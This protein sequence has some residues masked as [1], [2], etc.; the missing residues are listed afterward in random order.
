MALQTLLARNE[1]KLLHVRHTELS[2][3]A[4]EYESRQAELE[5]ALDEAQTEDDLNA[6]R[7]L[8]SEFQSERDA[9]QRNLDDVSAQIAAKET[10]LRELEA[11][12]PPVNAPA[13][14]RK[15]ARPMSESPTKYR[16]LAHMSPERRERFLASTEVT[17]FVERF[18]EKF[19]G[20]SGGAARGVSG[21]ELLIP[22][23]VLEVLRE[24][25]ENYSRLARYV[26][27]VSLNG[28]ARLPIMGAIPEAVWTEVC[29]KLNE[30]FLTVG[31]V[32][33]DNY[34]I[35]AYAA[36]CNATLEDTNPVL[37][38]EIIYALGVALGK[39]LDK[40]TVFGTGVGMPLGFV[41]RLAQTSAPAD[42]P[43]TAF[44]WTDLHQ[45]NITTIPANTHG[46]DLF[47]AI[48]TASGNAKSAYSDGRLFWIVNESTRTLLLSE[49][50]SFTASGAIA[51]GFNNVMPVVGGDIV[52]LPDDIIPGNAIY[53]GYGQLYVL[54]ER[55]GMTVAQSDQ[56]FFLQE[57][58]AFKASARYDGK[59]AIPE[60]FIA[61]GLGGNAPATAAEFNPDVANTPDASLRALSIGGLTLTPA[62]ASGTLTGYTAATTK[63]DAIINLIPATGAT[64]K[65]TVGGKA[66]QPGR[67][68]TWASGEN[69]VSIVVKSG[70]VTQTYSVTVTKS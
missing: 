43:A 22:E 62:F 59:P 28:N 39:T 34:K 11:A 15:E 14:V 33:L 20:A 37:A 44:P 31:Q 53:G 27:L 57:Q 32:S 52:T 67:A 64:A 70:S 40:S 46:I 45:S 68:F 47:K 65:I 63:P 54:G 5:T 19:R 17:D 35:G 25:I 61:I 26:R 4:A 6:V 12:A 9:W 21:A 49:A 24:T 48:V 30:L 41:T 13:T 58:T 1:L 18:R 10:E 51:T 60:G 29:G 3:K 2:D 36:I 16:A 38:N 42:Y 50:M 8:I 69:A 66:V 7:G 56:V 23:V 55:A